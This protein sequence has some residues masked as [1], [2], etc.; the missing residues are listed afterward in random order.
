MLIIIE[1]D[2]FMKSV[3]SIC[4]ALALLGSTV[5]AK[6]LISFEEVAGKASFVTL[7]AEEASQAK[8]QIHPFLN[9][10]LPKPEYKGSF[11][12][13]NHNYPLQY[14][15]QPKIYPWEKVTNSGK[16]TKENA[17]DF[18][19]SLKNYISNDMR[20]II[21]DKYTP[22]NPNWYQSI[23]IGTEREPI[24]GVYVGS[25]FPAGTL[26]GQTLDLTTYVYTLYDKRAAK[27][28]GDIWGRDLTSAMNPKIT[29]ET[30]QYSEGSVIVKFS[31][32][33]PCGSDWEPMK[34]TAIWQIYAPVNTS[35]GT[36]RSGKSECENSAT[37][38]NSSTPILTN[39]Y[40]MQ[41]DIIVK[42][43]KA[44][45][46]T[47]WVFSTLIYDK[48]AKGNDVWDKM[49]PLGAMW[50]G[51]SNVINLNPEALIPPV[52]VNPK[53]EENWININTPEYARST[54]GW[55]GRLS[56]P[57]DGAVATPAWTDDKYYH[58]GIATVGCM[59]CHSSAQ[60]PMTS[61]LLPSSTFPPQ[62]K[63]A[64]LSNDSNSAS[65]VLATP[66]TKAW[67][68]W[69]QSNDGV[70]PMGPKTSSGQLPVSLDYDMVTAF[71]AI[72]MWEAAKK[73]EQQAIK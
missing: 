18:V 51:D 17:Y 43:S 11:F 10:S 22:N 56:G 54:L 5:Q 41:C 15:P 58:T 30:T 48:D 16:I 12:K 23:W 71:K 59:N 47:G 20:G 35:N 55:D 14:E 64:P 62:T 36:A 52:Q 66:G 49:V 27:T 7:S 72:P 39:I 68:K 45:P 70:T 2:I 33:T 26:T 44:S 50:G 46:D 31:F 4:V 24:H 40:M 28:L 38:G 32:V 21:L 73:S 29:D 13:L 3:N 61:F 6:D 42:D 53:L 60:Y 57:N 1:K 25:G 19:M 63:Q 67:M 37:N 65:L 69:F 9:S 34:D 8:M